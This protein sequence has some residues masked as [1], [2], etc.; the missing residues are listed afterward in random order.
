MLF[1]PLAGSWEKGRNSIWKSTGNCTFIILC[2]L[3][4]QKT[5]E[6]WSK[7]IYLSN[8]LNNIKYLKVLLTPSIFNWKKTAREFEDKWNLP[9]CVAAIDGKHIVHQ[10]N[11]YYFNLVSYPT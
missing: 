11:Y 6:S 4:D 5:N 3:Y 1:S 10:V 2:K 8:I 9:H 7:N